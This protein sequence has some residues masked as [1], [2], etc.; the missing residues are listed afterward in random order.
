MQKRQFQN[1]QFNVAT[2]VAK[3]TQQQKKKTEATRI[4][5][6][7]PMIFILC[8]IF[9]HQESETVKFIFVISVDVVIE[10]VVTDNTHTAQWLMS[11]LRFII[12]TPHSEWVRASERAS[13]KHSTKNTANHLKCPV[14]K[15]SAASRHL[16][17]FL[18]NFTSLMSVQHYN[19]LRSTHKT[20]DKMLYCLDSR[21]E[22]NRSWKKMRLSFNFAFL[23]VFAASAHKFLIAFTWFNAFQ[24]ISL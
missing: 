16:F 18:F 21:F 17:H 10:F 4:S 20:I 6:P 3:E 24:T 13:W 22:V 7:C 8:D 9:K 23:S 2:I 5:K 1:F 14:K 11:S 15:A 19:L 12:S